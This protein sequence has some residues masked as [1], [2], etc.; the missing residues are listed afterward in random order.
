MCR[1]AL[2][3]ALHIVVSHSLRCLFAPPQA[4][5]NS[6]FQPEIF[7]L[8]CYFFHYLYN[9][10]QKPFSTS[11]STSNFTNWADYTNNTTLSNNNRG[12][13]GHEHMTAFSLI[14]MNGRVYD[15]YTS[16]FLSPDPFVQDPTNPQNYNRYSYVLNN[17]L[18]FTDQVGYNYMIDGMEVIAFR[19]LPHIIYLN[20]ITFIILFH[21]FIK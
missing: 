19:H 4:E 5:V 17:P 1:F 14:N 8:I 18:K 12:Y 21:G 6:G 9:M 3:R 7:F 13:T 2:L 20:T 10:N 11:V 16:Q 15:P